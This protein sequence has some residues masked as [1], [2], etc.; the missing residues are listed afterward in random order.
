[1]D[2]IAAPATLPNEPMLTLGNVT[3]RLGESTVLDSVT[4]DLHAGQTVALVG[5]NGAGK[6]TLLRVI[7]GLLPPLEGLR[8]VAETLRGMP[9]DGIAY[10]AQS[11]TVHWP[12]TVERTIA[13]GRLPTLS[14]LRQLSE[15]DE[16]VIEQAMLAADVA[17][18]QGR[19]V[20]EISG[21]ELA[22]VQIARLIASDARLVRADEPGS[23]L[24]LRHHYE[25]MELLAALARHERCIVVVMHDLSMAL[26]FFERIVVL[27]AGTVALD[28]SPELLD[29]EVIRRIYGVNPLMGTIDNVP[30]VLAERPW[31]PPAV[32]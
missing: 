27:D 20:N 3:V 17:H 12:L 5:P 8:V 24:D 13:L 30:F 23:G 16:Q 22:R 19:R 29:A 2:G 21:G 6:S 26:R 31:D 28:G 1:M 14:P 15:T 7:A 18:L 10:L 11:H 25:A 9:A 4:L 32:D